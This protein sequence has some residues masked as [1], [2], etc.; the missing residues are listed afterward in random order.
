MHFNVDRSKAIA[1][2]GVLNLSALLFDA[3]KMPTAGAGDLFIV[4]SIQALT[5]ERDTAH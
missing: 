4:I 2:E 5:M 3:N 1:T